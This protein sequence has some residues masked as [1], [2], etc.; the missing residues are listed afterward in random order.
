MHN[1]MKY[2]DRVQWEGKEL[3]WFPGHLSDGG[4]V[5]HLLGYYP[6]A[7][8]LDGGGEGSRSGGQ[9]PHYKGPVMVG[10]AVVQ[11][12]ASVPEEVPPAIAPGLEWVVVGGR[13]PR[14]TVVAGPFINE[15]DPWGAE[16]EANQMASVKWHE[17]AARTK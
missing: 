12:C 2:Y 10:A 5:V 11:E 8:P 6:E 15:A 7:A 9:W 16:R 3:H 1:T 17:W 14:G 4:Y 13:E